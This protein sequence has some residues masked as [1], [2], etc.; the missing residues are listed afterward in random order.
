MNCKFCESV[1][2]IEVLLFFL[3][4]DLVLDYI[5]R[6]WQSTSLAVVVVELGIANAEVKIF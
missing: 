6:N 5:I 1:E 4:H 3:P 2:I